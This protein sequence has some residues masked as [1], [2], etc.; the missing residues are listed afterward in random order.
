MDWYAVK[1]W[2]EAV[3]R[4]DMDA[5]HVHAGVLVHLVAV[6]CLR[7]PLKSPYPLFLVLGLTLANEAYDLTIDPW[8]ESVRNSQW[9]ESLKDLLNTMLLPCVL[10]FCARFFPQIFVGRGKS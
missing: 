9:A 4:L 5:L 2:I 7:K 3:S 8:P 6:A 1:E 10:L